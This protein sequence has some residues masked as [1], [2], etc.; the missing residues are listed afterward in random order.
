[1]FLI[2]DSLVQDFPDQTAES[3]G[4]G[5]DSLFVA[6]AR[7]Q[8]TKEDF[9]DASFDL[10]GGVGTLIEDTPHI[11]VAMGRAVALGYACTLFLPGA[12]AYP[13]GQIAG[14]VKRGG[15]CAHLGDDLLRRIH[16]QTGDLG[17]P[18]NGLLV[19]S[20]QSCQLLIELGDLLIDELEFLQCHL[21]QAAI[22]RMEPRRAVAALP[23]TRNLLQRREAVE[24]IRRLGKL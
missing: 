10:H 16:T 7:G 2:T 15:S 22:D 3:M 12:D 5:A 14:G 17:E 19:G 24:L 21:Q 6:E 13:G 23:D 20:Q 4:D 9:E 8:T 18:L 1:V 11:A